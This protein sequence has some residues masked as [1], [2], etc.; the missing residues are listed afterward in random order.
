MIGIVERRHVEALEQREDGQRGEPLGRRRQA[1][2]LALAIAQAERLDPV[3][4]VLG[5]IG[6][7]QGTAG[8][9][10]GLGE[11]TR[12]RTAIELLRA[13]AGHVRQRHGEIRLDEP[14]GPEPVR[15]EDRPERAAHVGVGRAR[16]QIDSRG[17]HATLA[18][19]DGNALAGVT[20]GV[21]QKLVPLHS[22]SHDVATVAVGGRPARHGAR[23]RERRDSTPDGNGGAKAREVALAIGGGRGTAR[24]VE[25]AERFARGVVDQPH[26]VAADPVHVRV[27]H[28]DRRRGG[29]RG[30]QRVAATLKHRDAGLGGQRMGRRDETVRRA[31]VGPGGRGR[32][33]AYPTTP[34]AWRWPAGQTLAR[35]PRGR[36]EPVRF[37]VRMA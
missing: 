33:A 18:R 21:G 1:D 10:R 5:Q 12:E 23:H 15:V 19:R 14:L 2:R 13:I 27:D 22:G 16:E 37:L 20:D 25:S 35:S 24:G 7:G 3:G 9:A 31:R 26:V 36:S 32:H 6:G 30:V 4:A 11:A 8:P 29:D 28:G 34:L 17:G